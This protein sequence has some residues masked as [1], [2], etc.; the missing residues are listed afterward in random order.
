MLGI[1]YIPQKRKDGLMWT[2]P[3]IKAETILTAEDLKLTTETQRQRGN[4]KKRDTSKCH[5]HVACYLKSRKLSLKCF[6]TSNNTLGL[7]ILRRSLFAII[8]HYYVYSLFAVT[9]VIIY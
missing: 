1:K 6:S 9:V 5:K 3:F 8:F 2:L 7:G 4:G